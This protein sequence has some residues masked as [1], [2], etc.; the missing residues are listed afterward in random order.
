MR[1]RWAAAGVLGAL[2]AAA[3]L[4][5]VA[6]P[7]R[8][9]VNCE[10]SR[11]ALDAGEL[12]MLALVNGARQ[13]AGLPALQPS[14]S[15]NRA[16]AWMSEDISRTI[17]RTGTLSHTDSLGRS[18]SQRARDC[19]YPG[20]AGENLARGSTSPEAVFSA[21]MQS[22]GHRANIL[23]S[24][25]VVIGIG[26]Y[27]GIWTLDFGTVNDAG[28]APTPSATPPRTP[29][30]TP[31][32][33]PTPTP[34]PPRSSTMALQLYSGFNLVTYAGPPAPPQQALASVGGVLVAV[35][36]W[37]AAD[38]TWQRYLDDAPAWANSLPLMLPG[39]AYFVGV[40]A[41]AVWSYDVPR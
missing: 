4:V 6:F 35:Y 18:P 5:G 32:P 11:D 15:L 23:G 7:A 8:A 38:G 26:H 30:T 3:A 1:L 29:T 19:G 25:Y 41:P 22:P 9:I 17:T 10:T 24:F 27:Q 34:V 14:A 28:A 13:Q 12:Q 16:A 31:T 40:T 33:T 37:N 20:S 39:E 2:C 36:H 21:W